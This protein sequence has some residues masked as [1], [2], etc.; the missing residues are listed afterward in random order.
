MRALGGF[1]SNGADVNTISQPQIDIRLA[2]GLILEPSSDVADVSVGEV[3]GNH[4]NVARFL[5]SM[6]NRSIQRAI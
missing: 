1:C 6:G 5:Q 3:W 4:R 2:C